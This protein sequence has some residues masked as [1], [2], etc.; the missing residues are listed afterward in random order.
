M[1]RIV[2][3]GLVAAAAVVALVIGIQLLNSPG[4]N[5]GGP[6]EEADANSNAN[7][8]AHNGSQHVAVGPREAF[9]KAPS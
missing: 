8:R 3:F 1:N 4:V 5:I 2:G 6:G 7:N 9:P